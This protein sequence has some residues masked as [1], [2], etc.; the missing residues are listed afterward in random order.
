[1]PGLSANQEQLIKEL[2]A[3]NN[4][5]AAIKVYREATGL[6]LKEAK[7]AVEAMERGEP[8]MDFA[9]IQFDTPNSALLE[10]QIKQF[11]LKRQKIQAVRIYREAHNCGLKDAKDAVDAIEAQMRKEARTSLPSAPTISDDPFAEDAQRNRSFIVLI[12]AIVV[13]VIGGMVFLFLTG[14]GF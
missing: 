14:S 9:P 5:I 10:E 3:K 13:I 2:I 7:D 1:M 8:I 6:G 4:K 11:L 12:F